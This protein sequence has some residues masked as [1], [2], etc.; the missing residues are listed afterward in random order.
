MI[1]FVS[2]YLVLLP[3]GCGK[4]NQQEQHSGER[5]DL[6]TFPG[7]SSSQQNNRGKSVKESTV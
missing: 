4:T 1:T 5:V 3:C 6:A 7:S 2:Y